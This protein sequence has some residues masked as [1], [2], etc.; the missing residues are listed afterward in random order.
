MTVPSGHILGIDPGPECSAYLVWDRFC[1][2]IEAKD[3]LKNELLFELLVKGSFESV[4]GMSIEMMQSRGMPVG[5]DVFE[6]CLWI[7]RF[8]FA[9]DLPFELV[10]PSTW[11][12]HFC[13]TTRAAKANV[14][15]VMRDRFG[16]PGRKNN[17]GVLYGVKDH[18]RD[19]LALAV[20]A[21]DMNLFG[22]RDELLCTSICTSN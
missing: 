11:R 18:L 17:P 12:S 20:Y 14:W 16:E 5:K 22:G 15:R 1:E 4:D 21:Q 3:M 6:T 9:S 8:T 2:K 19:A 13:G 10:Y 7:G